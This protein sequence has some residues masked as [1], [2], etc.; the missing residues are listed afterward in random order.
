MTDTLY[1][2]YGSN[3]DRDDWADW[4]ARNGQD[5]EVLEP[6]RPGW[7]VDHCPA[8]HYFSRSRGGGALD[9]VPARGQVTPGML[10]RVPADGWSALDR[11]EGAPTYYAHRTVPVLLTGGSWQTATT[12]CV[13]PARRQEDFVCPTADYVGIVQ[14]GL[15]AWGL[16]GEVHSAV[17]ENR[18]AP[19]LIRHLFAYGL[20]QSGYPMGQSLAGIRHRQTARIPGRLFDLGVYPGWQPTEDAEAAVF[21]ELLELN[22]PPGL[23]AV[24]DRYEGFRDYS[25]Q[26][27]YHRVLVTAMTDSGDEILAW[28][29]RVV[30]PGDAPVIL[31]GRWQG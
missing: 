20:L 27:L 6:V 16:P 13:T 25:G 28:C 7:L 2:A 18:P 22:D 26:S 23:L 5:T 10:F 31:G 11:K 1:F 19:P 9:V 12:Y 4:C 8:Y 3:L 15:S 21:G 30:R 17:A 29:Y 14:R 24:T